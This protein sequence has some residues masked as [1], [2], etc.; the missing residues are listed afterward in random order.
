M[1]LTTRMFSDDLNTFLTAHRRLPTSY[2][3]SFSENSQY[4]S[5]LPM[6]IGWGGAAE[7]AYRV[8]VGRNAIEVID[9][10]EEGE[11]SLTPEAGPYGDDVF[12][13]DWSQRISDERAR[14]N[15]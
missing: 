12:G 9:G 2:T 3:L 6:D 10:G 4:I 15:K 8:D 13:I 11:G 1:N 5:L 14:R 7:Q